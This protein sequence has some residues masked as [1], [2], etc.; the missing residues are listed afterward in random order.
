MPY[1]FAVNEPNYRICINN[2]LFGVPNTE[3]ARSQI[4]NVKKEDKLFIYIYGSQRIYGVYKAISNPL[5]ISKEEAKK[6]PW[7]YTVTDEKHG[8][9]PY[10]LFIDIINDYQLYI[11][12][13]FYDN[14]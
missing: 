12:I 6:G 14:N 3:R 2:R 5:S 4:S 7:N 13:K 11:L 9:Y 8:Y 10:R 1:I